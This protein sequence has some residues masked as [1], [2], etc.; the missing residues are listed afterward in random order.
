MYGK[1]NSQT[2]CLAIASSSC[3]SSIRFLVLVS[4]NSN[5]AF[6][7]LIRSWT[8]SLVSRLN[9]SNKDSSS[10][11]ALSAGFKVN[12]DSF[13]ASSSLRR[14]TSTCHN[15]FAKILL[16]R[17]VQFLKW[18]DYFRDLEIV[19]H[20]FVVFNVSINSP[21]IFLQRRK[22]LKSVKEEKFTASI[23]KKNEW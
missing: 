1:W 11:A 20:P 18:I 16:K 22:Q 19:N 13:S 23:K 8:F 5:N 6:C 10:F 21:N 12:W 15:H 7:R 9:T 3:W 2:C 17:C 4:S 14:Q